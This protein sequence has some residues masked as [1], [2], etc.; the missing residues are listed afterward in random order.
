MALYKWFCKLVNL[1]ITKDCIFE[2]ENKVSF[3]NK[4]I[5]QNLQESPKQKVNLKV[6]IPRLKFTARN[7]T[8]L[9]ADNSSKRKIGLK[10]ES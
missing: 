5:N 3:K 4:A 8:I 2:Y 6:N 9:I 10:Y 1:T 7:L